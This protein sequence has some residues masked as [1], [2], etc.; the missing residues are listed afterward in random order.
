[1]EQVISDIDQSWNL[2]ETEFESM[3]NRLDEA[4]DIGQEIVPDEFYD[5]L[6]P[7]FKERF[8]R[9]YERVRRDEVVEV[10]IHPLS[11]LKKVTE[12][13]EIDKWLQ[14]VWDDINA[15]FFAQ[16][17]LDGSALM[18]YNRDNDVLY[19]T[20]STKSDSVR[21]IFIPKEILDI[22]NIPTHNIPVGY[23]VRGEVVIHKEDVPKTGLKKDRSIAAGF[24]KSLD[25]NRAQY[26][27]FYAFKIHANE[28]T[29]VDHDYHY[30]RE[31]GFN[32]PFMT[33]IDREDITDE[34]LTQILHQRKTE[35]PYR[36]DGLVLYT[37]SQNVS[38]VDED[39]KMP[40]YAIAFK[41]KDYGVITTVTEI[42]W[43]E[44]LRG[45][46]NP[47]VYFDPVEV[48]NSDLDHVTGH[49]AGYL[50]KH[51]IWPGAVVEV[52]LGGEVTA[53]ILRVIEPSDNEIYPEGA[54]WDD[55]GI[56][57]YASEEGIDA[58]KK[59]LEVSSKKIGVKGIG[60]SNISAIVDKFEFISIE[61]V[62][63]FLFFEDISG[64]KFTNA[65]EKFFNGLYDNLRTTSEEKLMVFSGK[66]DG[67]GERK[68]VKILDAIPDLINL[69]CNL[70]RDQLEDTVRSNKAAGVKTTAEA[71]VNSLYNYLDMY[72]LFPWKSLDCEEQLVDKGCSYETEGIES[73]QYNE[74]SIDNKKRDDKETRVIYTTIPP[75]NND[76]RIS[77][78][79]MNGIILS[80]GSNHS[81]D[82]E[83][84]NQ[85]IL[86]R[87]R[88]NTYIG[89][90][91]I[92]NKASASSKKYITAINWLISKRIKSISLT[93]HPIGSTK[94]RLVVVDEKRTSIAKN[95][96]YIKTEA[97]ILTD[98][99]VSI[100][101]VLS[102][103]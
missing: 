56:F 93:Q 76:K 54:V 64:I 81:N 34:N 49:N 25:I 11:S 63:Q 69:A 6:L 12:Q 46:Y 100:K 57:I 75:L 94:R 92:A 52:G 48:D 36:V 23:A 53:G 62:L 78:D 96:T 86:Q 98:D 58:F 87:M 15:L 35:A 44:K 38:H 79:I 31:W 72:Q 60:P 43:N 97:D 99:V 33:E 29:T 61:S 41:L 27:K 67:F 2:S 102:L 16:D 32:V 24:L 1:M 8:N 85:L 5:N 9:D 20:K 10:P 51:G 26:M 42:R 19:Y 39:G 82:K 18:I 3:L 14:A 70:S 13:E 22:L 40:K 101:R 30:L 103:M 90:V 59:R 37:T 66:F 89:F 88:N 4:Y 65:E 17:K 47:T 73:I 21:Q 50:K 95:N 71:F 55:K 80:S 7:I 28:P 83:E 91:A 84:E 74:T 77:Q 45:R 68:L